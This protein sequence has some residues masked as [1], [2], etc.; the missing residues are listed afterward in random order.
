MQ[1]L[2]QR[3]LK[4]LNFDL[5]CGSSWF[6]SPSAA[7]VRARL[8]RLS[9]RLGPDCLGRNGVSLHRLR[10]HPSNIVSRV[11]RSTGVFP[12]FPV[13]FHGRFEPNLRL[14]NAVPNVPSVPGG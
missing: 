7:R 10:H 9:L 6:I 13:L 5:A 14:L 2:L 12:V 11:P 8:R 3:F 4:S 1:G